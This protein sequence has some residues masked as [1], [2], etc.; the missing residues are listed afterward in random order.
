[1]AASV[2]MIDGLMTT[3]VPAGVQ[4]DSVSCL[5]AR[6]KGTSRWAMESMDDVR[7]HTIWL[8][9]RT[10]CG[11]CASNASHEGLADALLRLMTDITILTVHSRYLSVFKVQACKTRRRSM[12]GSRGDE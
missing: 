11:Y 9:P 7:G 2:L 4:S 5:G 12:K 6:K 3:E 8:A 10:Q 1:M